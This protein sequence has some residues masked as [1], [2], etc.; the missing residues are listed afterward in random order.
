MRGKYLAGKIVCD[1]LR[2]LCYSGKALS[3]RSPGLVGVEQSRS[4]CTQVG[5]E[6]AVSIFVKLVFNAQTKGWAFGP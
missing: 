1:G 4:Q 6:E 5:P 2:Y 3:N